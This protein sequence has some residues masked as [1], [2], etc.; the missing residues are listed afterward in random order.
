MDT[1]PRVSEL[2][3]R[4]Q[5]LR[6]QGQIVTAGELCAD[7]PELA[8]ELQR[9]IVR[10]D[11]LEEFLGTRDE[12]EAANATP[13][14]FSKYRVVRILGDG[15]QASTLLAFDPDLRC[16]VVLKLYHRASSPTEQEK[17]LSE[18]QALARVRSPYVARCYGVERQ[19]GVPALVMEYIPGRNL[20]QQQ[21]VLPPR[22]RR[23][24]GTYE[25]TGRG[26]GGGPRLRPA[27]PRPQA[28]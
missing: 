17:V 25:A 28:R 21:S 6:Q 26:T 2:L 16:H 9:R 12:E 1:D 19:D 23:V 18:G 20:R 13:A 8:G 5:E 15:G 14:S 10:V 22:H 11:H 7:C 24:A 3:L 27:A 4:W